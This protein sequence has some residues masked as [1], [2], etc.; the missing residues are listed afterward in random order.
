MPLKVSEIS[1]LLDLPEATIH[2]WVRQGRIPVLA[3]NPEILFARGEIKK[4]AT[5]HHMPIYPLKSVDSQAAGDDLSLVEALR[6][7]VILR[8]IE[9]DS[10]EDA[11][12]A[13]ASL[14]P[15]PESERHLLLERLLQREELSSTGI[16]HQVA[17]PHP[18][19]P[20]EGVIHQPVILVCFLNNALD[21]GAIDSEPVRILILLLSPSTRAHLHLLSHIAFCLRDEN[22][23]KILH[24]ESSDEEMIEAFRMKE[25]LLDQKSTS[26]H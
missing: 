1:R 20:L 16:G 5:D 4:W 14:A 23:R 12:S 22:F 17:V 11:L 13:L 9:A 21:Y 26:G 2:R 25:S 10:V 18:R 8:D 7:G 3:T 15:V 24:P 6:R 19:R